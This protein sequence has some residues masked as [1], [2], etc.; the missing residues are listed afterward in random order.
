[1][2]VRVGP[3]KKLRHW[4]TDGF[5]TGCWKT[6][7]RPLDWK[8]CKLGYPKSQV[9]IFGRTDV[10][11]TSSNPTQPPDA[12]LTRE[13]T[14]CWKEEGWAEGEGDRTGWDGWMEWRLNGHSLCKFQEMVMDRTGG[15]LLDPWGGLDMTKWLNWAEPTAQGTL[16]SVDVQHSLDWEGVWG[17]M[18][19]S[20]YTA[21]P[22]A[23]L[24][25]KLMQPCSS[26]YVSVTGTNSFKNRT[27]KN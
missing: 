27:K 7:E 22:F 4:R 3:C 20:G 16:L 5:E 11:K 25:E 10:L 2:D 14:W 8:G 6:L 17:R 24:I 21:G 18:D 15:W 12:K 9:L 26:L 13:K 19:A 1:M 23:I